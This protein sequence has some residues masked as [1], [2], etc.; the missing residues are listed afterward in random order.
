[1]LSTWPCLVADGIEE[2]ADPPSGPVGFEVLHRGLSCGARAPHFLERAVRACFGAPVQEPEAGDWVEG[3]PV[4]AEGRER[5]PVGKQHTML[6][7]ERRDKVRA[8]VVHLP[9]PTALV[10]EPAS[11]LSWRE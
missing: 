5:S 1:M 7:I 2:P 8:V 11:G 3:R 9:R 6:R 10:L 4:A